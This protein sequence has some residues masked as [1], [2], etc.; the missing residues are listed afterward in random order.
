MVLRLLSALAVAIVSLILALILVGRHVVL[1]ELNC[2]N[3]SDDKGKV[4]VTYCD[5]PV[6][7]NWNCNFYPSRALTCVNVDTT[8][9][10][11]GITKF[12]PALEVT[13]WIYKQ[14]GCPMGGVVMRVDAGDDLQLKNIG[15]D[16]AI[17][18]YWCSRST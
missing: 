16:E 1:K 12:W 7:N 5:E 10:N 4:L 11:G 3:T 17:H 13:C 8:K 14:R 2:D 9:I 18:S 15:W 6:G